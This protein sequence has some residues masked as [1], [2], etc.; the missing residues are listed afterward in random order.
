MDVVLV[1]KEKNSGSEQNNRPEY[2][3]KQPLLKF[4]LINRHPLWSA[5]ENH[6]KY[7]WKTTSYARKVNHK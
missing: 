6:V 5:S 3:I 1:D 7:E 2:D 4:H